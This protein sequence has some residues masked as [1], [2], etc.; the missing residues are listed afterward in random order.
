MISAV[1]LCTARPDTSRVEG[2]EEEE[3]E[4]EE[5]ERG[6]EGGEG[7]AARPIGFAWSSSTVFCALCARLFRNGMM[8]GNA[9]LLYN[10]QYYSTAVRT[11][12]T[13]VVTLCCRCCN[14]RSSG[15]LPPL[16]LACF[17]KMNIRRHEST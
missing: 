17:A 6:E 13:F 9:L 7:S 10:K 16:D 14:S 11:I 8:P 4:E 15:P 1:A 5:E 12:Y 2:W 3:E